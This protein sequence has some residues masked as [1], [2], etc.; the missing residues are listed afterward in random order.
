MSLRAFGPVIVLALALAGGAEAATCGGEPPAGAAEFR[1]PVLHV[2]DGE[3]LCVALGPDPS[4]WVPVRLAGGAT[5][6]ST[7]PVPRGALMAAAFGQD[8]TCRIVGRDD[9]GVIAE[10]VS[11][12]GSLRRLS[13]RRQAIKAAQ[14]WR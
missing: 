1:G 5:R 2:L 7:A 4:E 6:A 10:C 14:A 3:R 8:V 12:R 9:E 11:D 13:Q